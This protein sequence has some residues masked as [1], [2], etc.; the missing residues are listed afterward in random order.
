MTK[1]AL[2]RLN[3]LEAV[4]DVNGKV[5]IRHWTWENEDWNEQPVLELGEADAI[6]V[7]SLSAN[8][9][10]DGRLLVVFATDDLSDTLVEESLQFSGRQSVQVVP[11]QETPTVDDVVTVAPPPPTPQETPIT[12]ITSEPI[13]QSLET[14]PVEAPAAATEIAPTAQS[15]P[16]TANS[17]LSGPLVGG[18][19]ALLV[20]GLAAGLALI[21][22]RRSAGK[23]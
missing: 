7:T 14:T 11:A 17:R 23:R 10:S 9:S 6:Q 18:V 5:F 12:I 8:T 21:V 3:L 2:G 19:L 1:D 20:V 15:G 4:S 16:V 22:V 13:S